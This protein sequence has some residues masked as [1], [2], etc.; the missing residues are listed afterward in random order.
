MLARP[1]PAA[2]REWLTEKNRFRGN[3]RKGRG[4]W[5]SRQAQ[6]FR[7]PGEGLARGKSLEDFKRSHVLLVAGIGGMPK[8]R[9]RGKAIFP[10]AAAQTAGRHVKFSDTVSGGLLHAARVRA[11]RRATRGRFVRAPAL[12]ACPRRSPLSHA[13][14]SACAHNGLPR[15]ARPQSPR[16]A[17]RQRQQTTPNR[18]TPGSLGRSVRCGAP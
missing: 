6:D 2:S 7:A 18:P 12:R 5:S 1:A 17:D 13:R 4:P 10:E 15:R 8:N 11:V 16:A 9:E 3:P 14:F